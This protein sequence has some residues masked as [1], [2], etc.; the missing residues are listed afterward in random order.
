MQRS[1]CS[2]GLLS[3]DEGL[4]TVVHVLGELNFVAAEAA[5][6]GDVEDAVVG[7]GVLAVGAAD[8]D[9]VLVGDSLHLVLFLLELREV[10]VDGGTHAGTE[11]GG[12]G[13]DV[14]EVV[15]VGE[16]GDFLDLGG[17]DGEALEDLADVGALLHGDDAELVLFVDPHEEGLV[18]VVENATSL[19]PLTLK[20]AG[21]EVLVSALEKEVVG[22]EG[23]ALG[24]GHRGERIVLALEFA[25]EGGEGLGDFGLD[26]AALLGG[27]GG[28]EGEFGEVA[29][30]TDAGGVDHLV[31]VGGEVGAAEFGVVHGGDVLVCGLVTVVALDDLV[32][33]G[34]EIVVG[35]VGSGVN[36]DAGVGPLGT[37]EDSLAEGEAILVLAVLALLPHVAGQ[38]L[39]EEGL[40]SAGEVGEARN[41]F[42]GTQVRAHEAAF[43]FG[44]GNLFGKSFSN[45]R[46]TRIEGGLGGRVDL[47]WWRIVIP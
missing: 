9:V 3:L 17:G 36:T 11:V 39:V 43:G 35:F 14:A 29:G 25:V 38:A 22:D 40:G 28:A 15:V 16:L 8:L 1:G 26:L 18:V 42:G 47:R 4:N 7:L 10:D 37:G 13:R 27:D 34:C 46:W 2:E 41:V 19:G 24:V 32:H 6:V 33:E 44:G 20:T 21:L 30:D 12:A 45:M 23:V 31:F 5:Q